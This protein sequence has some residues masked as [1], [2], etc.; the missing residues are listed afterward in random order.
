MANPAVHEMLTQIMFGDGPMEAL[1][2]LKVF[3]GRT[4]PK[5]LQPVRYFLEI[6]FR[7]AYP[8]ICARHVAY[9]M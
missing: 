7:H 9:L 4:H 1:M 8:E 3:D 5:Y 2:R 6:C